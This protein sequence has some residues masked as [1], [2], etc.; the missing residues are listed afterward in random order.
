MV[1]VHALALGA[2]P[3]PIFVLIA[4]EHCR[5]LACLVQICMICFWKMS[6]ESI[7]HHR[8]Q[9]FQDI[10]TENGSSQGQHPAWT[11]SFVPFSL[12]RRRAS[13]GFGFARLVEIG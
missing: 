9:G 3:F 12:E 5:L 11:G 1:L 7:R 6:V 8:S 2:R 10:S 13:Q 4:A